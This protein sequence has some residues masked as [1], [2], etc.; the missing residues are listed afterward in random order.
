MAPNSVDQILHNFLTEKREDKQ[1]QL[2]S[3]AYAKNLGEVRVGLGSCCVASGS[4]DVHHAL[5][6]SLKDTGIQ[7]TIKRVGCVGM[8]HRV[9]LVEIIKPGEETVL[10]DKVAAHEV[11]KIMRRHFKTRGLVYIYCSNLRIR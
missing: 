11:K 6:A 8:C 3:S 5:Q 4:A 2:K 1:K 10:Y 9:P 7:T